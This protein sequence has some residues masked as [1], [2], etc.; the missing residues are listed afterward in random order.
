M[1][2]PPFAGTLSSGLHEFLCRSG[3]ANPK[4]RHEMAN[5]DWHIIGTFTPEGKILIS[6]FSFGGDK[7][8]DSPL[9]LDETIEA[10]AASHE[11]PPNLLLSAAGRKELTQLAGLL[12][13]AGSDVKEKLR[14]D[15]TKSAQVERRNSDSKM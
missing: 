5:I 2:M 6:G 8:F 15:A 1:L 12:S 4:G 14:D 7:L 13:K 3:A 11:I 9:D 10:L